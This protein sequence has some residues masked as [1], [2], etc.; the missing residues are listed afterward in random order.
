[1]TYTNSQIRSILCGLGYLASQY[2]TD[3]NSSDFPVTN[4]DRSLDDQPTI[5]AI[6]AFQGDYG[7]TQDGIVGTETTAKLQEEMNAIHTELNAVVQPQP[8]FSMTEPFYGPRTVNAVEN[9]EGQINVTQD[10]IASQSIRQQLNSYYN[11]NTNG[12][13][14]EAKVNKAVAAR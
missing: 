13:T 5:N 11:G 1:M 9:F 3:G 6:V 14:D 10:G 12:N 2:V 4:D 8:P 7:L